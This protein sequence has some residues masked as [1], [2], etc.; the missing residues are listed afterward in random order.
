MRQPPIRIRTFILG[1]VLL[2]LLLPTLAGG[3]GWLIE[4]DHQQSGTQQRLHTALAYLSSHRTEMQVPASVHGFTSLLDRLDLLAQLV[5]VEA[6]R[7]ET[8]LP[9]PGAHSHPREAEGPQ[10]EGTPARLDRRAR[11]GRDESH[12]GR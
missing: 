3:A 9:Q 1:T 12:L 4:R 7:E 11:A 2:L 5:L 10:A 6:V 8:A